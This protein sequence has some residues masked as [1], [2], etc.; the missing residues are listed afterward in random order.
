MSPNYEG[1]RNVDL[2]IIVYLSSGGSGLPACPT[3]LLPLLSICLTIQIYHEIN[4]DTLN[5]D[6]ND[7]VMRHV[8]TQIDPTIRR[9]CVSSHLCMICDLYLTIYTL[10]HPNLNVSTYLYN[11]SMAKLVISSKIN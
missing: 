2:S 10:C 4:I 1:S 6:V 3:L 11:Y 8:S 7:G 5:M 9:T